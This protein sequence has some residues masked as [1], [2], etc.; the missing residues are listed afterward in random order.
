MTSTNWVFTINNPEQVPLLLTDEHK[1]F[2]KYILYQE[3]FVTTRHLQGYL[4]TRKQTRISAL[5]KLFPTAH[6]EK[7]RGTRKQ[8]VEY[9]T[10]EESRVSGPY[11]WHKDELSFE[12]FISALSKT[13]SNLTTLSLIKAMLDEGRSDQDIADEHFNT[14]VRHHRAFREYRLL[15]TKPRSSFDE[16]IVVIGPSGTGKSR[17]AMDTYPNAYWKQRSNWWDGYQGQE[18]IILDEFYGWIPYDLLLRLCDRYPLL[19]ES[20][21]GQIQ[22]GATRIVI[23]SNLVPSSWYK[24]VYQPSLR[25]RISKILYM[26]TLGEKKEYSIEEWEERGLAI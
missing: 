22:C 21:G 10:K 25:R 2:L 23:T 12:V 6:F 24:N 4:E 19:L 11:F 13:N 7:R 9:C 1:A 3:E 20:K 17:F 26:P 5:K 8:A 15:K 18:T 14:W 16:L